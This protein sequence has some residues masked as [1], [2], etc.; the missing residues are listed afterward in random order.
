[1]GEPLRGFWAR[2]QQFIDGFTDDSTNSWSLILTL[3][4]LGAYLL[5]KTLN[6][7]DRPILSIPEILWN[8]FVYIMPSSVVF[9]L[10]SSSRSSR[11]RSGSL[12]GNLA[13]KSDALRNAFGIDA[14]SILRRRQAHPGAPKGLGNWDNSC[15]Q[16]SVLQAL[17]SLAS[18]Q[19][20]FARF[21]DDANK[22]PDSCMAEVLQ[23]LIHD[24]NDVSNEQRQYL[25]TPPKLKNMSSWQQQDA[26]EY[27]SKLVEAIE[28][29]VV[30]KVR[31]QKLAKAVEG[32]SSLH[33]SQDPEN[34]DSLAPLV[35]IASTRQASR[36]MQNPL[37]GLL[38]QRVGCTRCGHT[39]GLSMIPFNCITL[40]LGR[41]PTYDVK[42]CLDEYCNLDY[43][44]DVDCSRCTLLRAR[45][46]LHG[47]L[48]DLQSGGQ[49]Q[50]EEDA[51]NSQDETPTSRVSK[52]ARQKLE[53][54][55]SSLRDED[56]SDATLSK[57]CQLPNNARVTST[58]SRQAVIMKAPQCLVMHVNRSL[59]DEYTGAQ[60]KNYA[61]VRY[62]KVFDLGPWSVGSAPNAAATDSHDSTESWQMD[63]SQPMINRKLGFSQSYPYELKAVVT[64]YGR[65]EN[66]HYICYRPM[67]ISKPQTEGGQ[68]KQ[69]GDEQTGN[70][71]DGKAFQ[72]WRISDEDVSPVSEENVYVQSGA[73]LLFYERIEASEDIQKT[74]APSERDTLE[75]QDIAG[76][77]NTVAKENPEGDRGEQDVV[78]GRTT[79]HEAD[80]SLP[81][82]QSDATRH[83]EIPQTVSSKFQD[84]PEPPSYDLVPSNQSPSPEQQGNQNQASIQNEVPP[85]TSTQVNPIYMQTARHAPSSSGEDPVMRQFQMIATN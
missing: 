64:H 37:E 82:P 43:I 27:F 74:D 9:A 17:S 46:D 49:G 50:S 24:L 85:E 45:E 39:E 71:P 53:V 29:D 48:E 47:I 67:P 40:P 16:N 23:E 36:R 12:S 28:K 59:F 54:I 5:Q 26:Q 25:W 73:F 31:D 30:S 60:L 58:K 19:D 34:R 63:P 83:A 65:H 68:E 66:G 78:S 76:T 2:I 4:V 69:D 35:S 18:F 80:D 14:G 72:W 8:S 33:I 32:L 79:C 56:F 15:Y 11:Q 22:T 55:E 61:G 84:T 57:K 7:L 77:D 6:Y 41:E 75:R 62:P 44:E 42:D 13:E 21:F 52:L 10:G 1:M 51:K 38:A 81:D 70:T 20:F 3:T